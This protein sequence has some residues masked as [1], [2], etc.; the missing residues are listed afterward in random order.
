MLLV[1]YKKSTVEG[2]LL[3]K[4]TNFVPLKKLLFTALER[5]EGE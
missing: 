5:H 1:R 4:F 3:I 2:K